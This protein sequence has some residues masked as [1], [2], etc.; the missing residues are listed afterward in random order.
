MLMNILA[1]IGMVVIM[2][3]AT[4]LIFSGIDDI[5]GASKKGRA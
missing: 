4:K 5:V 3:A 2:T 1:T